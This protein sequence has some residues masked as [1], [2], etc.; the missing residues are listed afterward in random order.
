M[1]RI[2]VLDIQQKKADGQKIAM[3]T[4][5][6][7]TMAR[8]VDLAG[9]DIVLVGDSLGMVFQGLEDT[10]P[11]T[12]E[13][14]AYHARAVARGLQRA[15]LCVDMP[16]MSYQLSPEQA[17]M[18]AGRLV[19]EGGA[20]S[21]KL[22]GGERVAG[23]ISR[24][25]ESGIPVMGHVG[26][27]PQSVHAM[28]GFRVQGKDA[29]S[30]RR[31]VADAAAVADAGAFAIVLEGVP[32][33]VAAEISATVGI[34]TI[35][36]GAGPHCDG[37]VLVCTD[38]LGMDLT[39]QPKFVKRYAQLETTITDAVKTY[40][41]EVRSGAFPTEAQSFTRKGPRTIAKIYS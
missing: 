16:F 35:G 25:V 24:I 32:I 8:L 33:D 6:D 28:G 18:N 14:M 9:V 17:L 2:N 13:E 39:F 30:A 11:V 31:V 4:A 38:L 7:R 12:L 10:L 23:A 37:Q 5:Y 20:Q 36:I 19:K 27:T 22:E 34:P 29:E 1:P 26:L 3:V 15:H 21:I 41:D 40:I